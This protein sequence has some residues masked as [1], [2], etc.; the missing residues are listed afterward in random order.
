MM[1]VLRQYFPRMW[2]NTKPQHKT[3]Y[4]HFGEIE[5]RPISVSDGKGGSKILYSPTFGENLKFFFTYQF[6]FMYVRYF[7]WNFAGRQNN[8]ESQGE[9]QHGNWISG[10]GFI[11]AWRLGDQT[12]L[13]PSMKNPAKTQFYFLPLILGLIGFFFQLNRSKKDTWIVSLMFIMTGLAIIVYLKPNTF[14]TK[15][16]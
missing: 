7:M 1:N 3:L 10:I 4:E 12:N 15:R 2:S 16:A 6:N 5:G 8:I 11:D 14:A 9:I 13:P